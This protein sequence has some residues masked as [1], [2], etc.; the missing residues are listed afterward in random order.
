[1]ARTTSKKTQEKT[2]EWVQVQEGVSVKLSKGDFF[3]L[4]W[5]G[6][7]IH[8]CA[9]RSGRNGDFISWPSF[10]GSDGQYVKRAYVYAERDSEDE[11]ILAAVVATV[12]R[13][14]E[15]G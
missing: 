7:V 8:G 4:S 9:V 14:R 12:Q 10:K 1:M 11:K 2:R 15:E 6:A 3:S 5:F 13:E